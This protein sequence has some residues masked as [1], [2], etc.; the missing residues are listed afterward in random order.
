MSRVIVFSSNGRSAVDLA[1]ELTLVGLSSWAV[2]DYQL[3]TNVVRRDPDIACLVME[4]TTDA[5]S[6]CQGLRAQRPELK[7]VSIHDTE[8]E[9]CPG[10]GLDCQ[11][12]L[13]RDTKSLLP[14]LHGIVG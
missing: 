6:I 12:V 3:A 14:V 10:C 13:G 1:T 8:T 11:H 9:G 5:P 2:N 7:I 4:P